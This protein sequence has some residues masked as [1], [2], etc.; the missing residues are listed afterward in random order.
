MKLCIHMGEK[1]YKIVNIHVSY[2]DVESFNKLI[3]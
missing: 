2:Y 3:N 1:I